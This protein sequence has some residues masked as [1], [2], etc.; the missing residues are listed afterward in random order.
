MAIT[1]V[2]ED[3]SSRAVRA[4]PSKWKRSGT[5]FALLMIA[6]AVIVLAAVMIYPAF[7]A[8]QSSFY[9]HHHPAGDLCRSCELRRGAEL[10]GVL[11]RL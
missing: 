10:A 5:T 3:G 2:A 4:R 7:V 11:V 6:P 9:R 1:Q 8:F